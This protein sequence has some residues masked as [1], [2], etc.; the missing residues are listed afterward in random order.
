M[1]Q[2]GQLHLYGYLVAM[3]STFEELGT[4]EVV[5]DLCNESEQ[6]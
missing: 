5:I 4:V 1:V 3:F 2:V 6:N